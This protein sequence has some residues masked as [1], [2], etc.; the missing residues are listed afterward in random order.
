VSRCWCGA[1]GEHEHLCGGGMVNA[2]HPGYLLVWWQL[3]R[4]IVRKP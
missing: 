4:R 2:F 1:E 3:L